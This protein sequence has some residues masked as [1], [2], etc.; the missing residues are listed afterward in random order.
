MRNLLL[1]TGATFALFI[2]AAVAD[3]A[4][5]KAVGFETKPLLKANQTAAGEPLK[6]PQSGKPEITSAMATI[7]PGGHT[8]LHQHPVVTFIYVLDGEF[9]IHQGDSVLHYKAGDAVIEPIG[10]LMQN[11][12]PGTGVTRVLVVYVGEEGKPNMIVAK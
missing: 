7:Q 8:A 1:V 9:D 6:F 2:S 11:F 5:N 12:N 10:S 3:E 4:A